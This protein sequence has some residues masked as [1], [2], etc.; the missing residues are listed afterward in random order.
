MEPTDDLKFELSS[1]ERGMFANHTCAVKDPDREGHNKYV[2]L[3]S[4]NY[5]DDRSNKTFLKVALLIS[6]YK[7]DVRE[8]VTET[9]P[10]GK[11]ETDPENVKILALNLIAKL[12]EE[13][14]AKI[15][16][17]AHHLC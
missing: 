10:G 17:L 13:Y 7:A 5:F 1:F 14:D 6:D 9:I 15:K 2:Y 3:L 16:N 12:I 8:E 4:Q 11:I